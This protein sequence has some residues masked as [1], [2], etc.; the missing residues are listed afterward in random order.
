M[1]TEFKPL[2][3]E[4]FNLSPEDLKEIVTGAQTFFPPAGDEDD[5][6]TLDILTT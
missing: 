1:P 6:D 3:L 2:E 4:D 5:E